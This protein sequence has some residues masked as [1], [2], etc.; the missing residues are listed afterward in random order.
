MGFK[1]ERN[2]DMEQFGWKGCKFTFNALTIGEQQQLD[3]ERQKWAASSD[4]KEISAAANKIVDIMKSKFVKGQAL[5]EK[6]DKF[7]VKVEDFEHIP[8]DVFQKLTGWVTSGE[9]DEAFLA[10]SMK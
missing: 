4:E 3:I 9:V 8:F 1:A 5:D 2:Y 7:D 10:E 6:G